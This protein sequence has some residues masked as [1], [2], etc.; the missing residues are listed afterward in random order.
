M[1]CFYTLYCT[2][3]TKREQKEKNIVKD[4]PPVT[5]VTC[6]HTKLTSFYGHYPAGHC[7]SVHHTF[8]FVTTVCQFYPVR[9]CKLSRG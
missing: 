9:K 4:P 7:L 5:Q 2:T 3:L 8:S 6:S 1:L